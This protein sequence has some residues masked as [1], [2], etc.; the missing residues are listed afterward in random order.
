M[1]EIKVKIE[2]ITFDDSPKRRSQMRQSGIVPNHVQDLASS[3][4]AVGQKEPVILEEVV[5]TEKYRCTDGN[6]RCSAIAEINKRRNHNKLPVRAVIKSY[7]SSLQRLEDQIKLN[8]HDPARSSTRKD[9]V[10]AFTH[11]IKH[12]G[13]C[14]DMLSKDKSGK[15]NRDTIS[16]YIKTMIPGHKEIAKITNEVFNSMPG[17]LTRIKNYTKSNAISWFNGYSHMELAG[18]GHF[19]PNGNVYYFGGNV[20]EMS[21]AVGQAIDKHIKNDE[22]NEI[23]FV[24]WHSKCLGKESDSVKKFRKDAEKK[25]KAANKYCKNNIFSKILFLPQIADEDCG[26]R[27]IEVDLSILPRERK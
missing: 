5:G 16:K 21:T 6:H 1:K 24:A 25:L 17:D 10:Y 22:I 23:V 18:S 20:N 3:I 8:N 15:E 19:G 12:D 14:G 9:L 13:A 27:P 2:D 26:T 7:G 4:E 11:A